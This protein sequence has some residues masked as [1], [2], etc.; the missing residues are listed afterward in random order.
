MRSN[1]PMHGTLL[2]S[3]ASR[4]LGY[5][6]AEEFLQRDWN[7]VGTVRGSAQTR[8]HE[9]VRRSRDRV[10]IENVDIITLPA[11]VARKPLSTAI[12]ATI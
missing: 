5:A 12:A 11:V 8:L 7:V 6:M 1:H 10:E 4:G 2:L 9:L 3:G